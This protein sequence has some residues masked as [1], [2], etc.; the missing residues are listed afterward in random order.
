MRIIVLLFN[1]SIPFQCKI[2]KG[3]CFGH[4]G[5]AIV[6]NKNVIIKETCIIGSCVTIWGS[7]KKKLH[8]ILEIMLIL[9]LGLK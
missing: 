5:I 1:C 9:P 6:I 7:S 4:G 3:T 8:H 2:G